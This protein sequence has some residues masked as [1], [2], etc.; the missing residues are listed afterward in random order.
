MP[1]F[2]LSEKTIF[3]PPHLALKSG[4]LAVGG[5]LSEKRLLAAYRQGVFPWYSSGDPILWWSPDPRLVLY[6][7]NLKI[8]RSLKKTL[9]KNKFHVSMDTSFSDVIYSCAAVRTEKD[10]GTW[11]VPEMM[12]AYIKLFSAGYAHSVE[13][14]EGDILVGGL[15]GIALGKCFFGESMFSRT[16]DASKVAFVQLVEYLK[17]HDYELIDC[18]VRT[19]HLMRFGAREVPR[20]RFLK[21]LREFLKAP[22][23][24]GPWKDDEKMWLCD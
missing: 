12:S 22:T 19:E 6:P 13:A 2:H 8:S 11:I 4:L 3:P 16:T 24:L 7:K 23:V 15:Y 1:V 20:A 9:K 10:E 21:Q 14:W 5:D 17:R 18:Q